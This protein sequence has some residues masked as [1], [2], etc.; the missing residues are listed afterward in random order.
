MRTRNR[1]QHTWMRAARDPSIAFLAVCVAGLLSAFV[2]FHSGEQRTGLSWLFFLR[3]EK[4]APT[5]V[6]IVDI[7]D[8]SRGKN[9]PDQIDVRGFEC[10]PNIGNDVRPFAGPMPRCLYARLIDI[11]AASNAQAIVIDIYFEKDGTPE[12]D[13]ILA[14]AMR[15][16]GNVIILRRVSS[17]ISDVNNTV[18]AQLAPINR[19][20][21]DAAFAWAPFQ[22]PKGEFVEE[23]WTKLEAF[24][25]YATLPAMALLMPYKDQLLTAAAPIG[26]EELVRELLQRDGQRSQATEDFLAATADEDMRR[27]LALLRANESYLLNFFGGPGT[28]E[29]LNGFELLRSGQ[30]PNLEGRTV[31]IGQVHL[32]TYQQADSFQTAFSQDNGID[33]AGVEIAATA[34]SNLYREQTLTRPAPLTLTIFVLAFSLI[35]GLLV[36]KARPRIGVPAVFIILLIMSVAALA[37]FSE[38]LIWVPIVSTYA[39]AG[40]ALVTGSFLQRENIRRWAENRIPDPIRRLLGLVTDP[41]SKPIAVTGL[42][43]KADVENFTTASAIAVDSSAIVDGLDQYMTDVS[44]IVWRSNGLIIAPADDSFIAFWDLPLED[45][46]KWRAAINSIL[47]LSQIP[48]IVQGPDGP[49]IRQNRIG[50]DYGPFSV[51][52][53]GVENG[54]ALNAHGLVVIRAARLETLNKELGTRILVNSTL[55]HTLTNFTL[56]ELGEHHLKGIDDP[57]RVVE[58]SQFPQNGT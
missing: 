42:I 24:G 2:F 52:G 58:L 31:F 56:R 57:V 36:T 21:D 8:I 9:L 30:A 55:E 22:L 54:K 48:F 5:E 35:F 20:I 3:G 50:V 18:Q 7:D 51:G 46:D 11:L 47:E 40:T 4:P 26:I 34:F 25:G 29:V 10:I 32:D 14:A 13:M 41:D 45:S 49:I 43:L 16:A 37:L 1:D 17:V 27:K 53:M 23:Y 44:P 38:Q 6:G 39:M 19:L 33:L 15:D 28:I 12:E